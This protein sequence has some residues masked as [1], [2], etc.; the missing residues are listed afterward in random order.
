MAKHF[1][2][3]LAAVAIIAAPLAVQAQSVTMAMSAA[4][5]SADPHYHTFSPNETL[6]IHVYERLVERDANSN[7][8]PG[9]ALSWKLIDDSTWEFKL[10]QGVKFHDGSEFTAAD[11]AVLA[12]LGTP[13]AAWKRRIPIRCG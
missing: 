12:S 13:S 6:D 11:V 10:R 8:I 9:L 2:A 7:L 1:A 3:A 5:T 4:P